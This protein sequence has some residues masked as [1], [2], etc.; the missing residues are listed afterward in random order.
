[1]V[2]RCHFFAVGS[3]SNHGRCYWEASSCTAFT[4]NLYHVYKLTPSFR[5]R[6]SGHSC[7]GTRTSLGMG[8]GVADCAHLCAEATNCT[9]FS[10]GYGSS[11]GQCFKEDSTCSGY[12]ARSYNTYE[13][14]PLATE[15]SVWWIESCKVCML[16]AASSSAA[17]SWGGDASWSTY[18]IKPATPGWLTIAEE[19][20]GSGNSAAFDGDRQHFCW[21]R[22]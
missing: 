22:V 6:K 5:L 2:C 17:A 16:Q 15:V 1:M 13:V 8:V 11:I 14:I 10:V 19:R 12:S 20:V 7:D 3:G 18:N 9:Y 4:P 21:C